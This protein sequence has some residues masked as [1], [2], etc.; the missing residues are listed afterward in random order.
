[1]AALQVLHCSMQHELKLICF[2]G[3]LHNKD[4]LQTLQCTIVFSVS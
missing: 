1:M 2:V 4:A 3:L